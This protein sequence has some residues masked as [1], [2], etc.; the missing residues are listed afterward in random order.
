MADILDDG[1]FGLFDVVWS[2]LP[3]EKQIVRGAIA[4]FDG[5]DVILHEQVKMLKPG[6][7]ARD[8]D[9]TI[10][11]HIVP[12]KHLYSTYKQAVLGLR[13]HAQ[14]DTLY[15]AKVVCLGKPNM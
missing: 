7:E 10:V 8:A 3:K 1:K 12:A 9:F 13:R 15:A 6:Q 11:R 4:K 5:K 14:D 2:F